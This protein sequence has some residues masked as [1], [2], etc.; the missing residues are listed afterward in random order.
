MSRLSSC[1]GAL[2]LRLGGTSHGMS[3]L[4]S[5]DDVD[6]VIVSNNIIDNNLLPCNT[7]NL[8]D[9]IYDIVSLL[10]CLVDMITDYYITYS[11][12]NNGKIFFK[13]FKL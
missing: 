7:M 5:F 8:S 10:M 12:W 6:D 2:S 1:S 9:W 11:F 3:H 13:F 4:P